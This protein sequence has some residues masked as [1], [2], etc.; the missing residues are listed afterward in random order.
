[1]LLKPEGPF[2]PCFAVFHCGDA[3]TALSLSLL[4]VPHHVCAAI[5]RVRASRAIICPTPGMVDEDHQAAEGLRYFLSVGYQDAHVL[6]GILVCAF[7]GAGERV[8]C[9]DAKRRVADAG[10]SSANV[11][12]QFL[13]IAL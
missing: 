1:M 2:E 4:D 3:D 11:A 6:R 8:Q 13:R 5:E 10:E 7:H 9:D 12:N